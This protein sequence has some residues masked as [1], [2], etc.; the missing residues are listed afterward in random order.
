VFISLSLFVSLGQKGGEIGR[1]YVAELCSFFLLAK[2]HPVRCNK[3]DF[4]LKKRVFSYQ[5]FYLERSNFLS[6]KQQLLRANFFVKD[7]QI[8][9]YWGKNKKRETSF[10]YK[11]CNF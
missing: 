2:L 3:S 8:K 11:S 7:N 9:I 5:H 1:Q 6:I 4:Y 10:N